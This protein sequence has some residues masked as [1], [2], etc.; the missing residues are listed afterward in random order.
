MVRFT[1]PSKIVRLLRDQHTVD[2]Y[3]HRELSNSEKSIEHILPVRVVASKMAQLDPRHLYVT[4]RSLNRFR[5]DYAFGGTREMISFSK[6]WVEHQG[7]FRFSIKRIFYPRHG[8]RLIAQVVWDMM[9]RYPFLREEEAQIFPD[10]E[11]WET[12][13]KQPW[14]PLEKSMYETNLLIQKQV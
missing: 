13:S 2:I 11:I 5:S 8:H 7:C 14:T 10:W 4:D 9:Q 1:I 12:W 6:N 3:C